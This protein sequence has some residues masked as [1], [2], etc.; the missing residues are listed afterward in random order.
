MRPRQTRPRLLQAMIDA[1]RM[2]AND[3]ACATF[4]TTSDLNAEFPAAAARQLGWT[5]VAL[6]CSKEVDVPASL[7]MCIR[8]LVLH[9]TDRSAEDIVHVYNRGA[10]GLRTDMRNTRTTS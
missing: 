9:N 5:D 6:L 3:I 1:N 8:V 10:A 4:T 2:E 7:P